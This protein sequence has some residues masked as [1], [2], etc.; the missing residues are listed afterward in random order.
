[1]ELTALVAEIV[2]ENINAGTKQTYLI[3][4][5]SSFLLMSMTK[6]MPEQLHQVLQDEQ[7]RS[8]RA[9][10]KGKGYLFSLLPGL[11]G[12]R[13]L[14]MQVP[15][16]TEVQQMSLGH[17]A[18]AS[19]KLMQI[20]H[21]NLTVSV[22]TTLEGYNPGSVNFQADLNSL[23]GAASHPEG[24]GGSRYEVTST[25]MM[26]RQSLLALGQ[27]LRA[28]SYKYRK[29]KA[30]KK[31]GK[32]FNVVTISKLKGVFKASFRDATDQFQSLFITGL[33]NILTDPL[34]SRL[35][36]TFYKRLR[37]ELKTSTN[38]GLFAKCG[39]RPIWP[40]YHK[41]QKVF[42][43]CYGT[44]GNDQKR[45]QTFDLLKNSA[46]YGKSLRALTVLLM[47]LIDGN[48]VSK[49]EIKSIFKKFRIKSLN[50]LK[51]F[52]K[53]IDLLNVAY[54]VLATVTQKKSKSTLEMASSLRGQLESRLASMAIVDSNGTTYDTLTD[55]PPNIMRAITSF[56]KYTTYIPPAERVDSASEEDDDVKVANVQD[57]NPDNPT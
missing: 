31:E 18:V 25:M 46:D 48:V 24:L 12:K 34:N 51:S 41:I 40:S 38:E 47:P 19:C 7:E 22:N 36:G 55:V 29:R 28:H 9:S 54:A 2:N 43:Q 14:F 1:M 52:H 13:H 49:L 32:T 23:V 5:V 56:G 4:S 6:V 33:W 26:T 27:T 45:L 10:K 44:S 17:L 53:E 16:H 57:A 8:I 39:Y 11:E 15:T 21:D 35:P 42:S 20:S 30:T 37:E 3:N 50:L